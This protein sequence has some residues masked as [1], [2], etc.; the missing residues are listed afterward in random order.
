[1]T[2]DKPK[3]GTFEE[4]EKIVLDTKQGSQI[5]IFL[6]KNQIRTFR[7]EYFLNGQLLKPKNVGA[8]QNAYKEWAKLIQKIVENSP[9]Y[10]ELTP[11]G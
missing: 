3:Y 7:I 1:M 11:E 8:K 5:E 6:K 2:A 4:V 10:I 9:D